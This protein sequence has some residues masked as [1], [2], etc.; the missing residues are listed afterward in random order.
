MRDPG[1]RAE[2]GIPRG[3]QCGV[4]GLVRGPVSHAGCNVGSVIAYM[5]PPVRA[6]PDRQCPTRLGKAASHETLMVPELCDEP[7]VRSRESYNIWNS[8]PCYF[9]K[10]PWDLHTPIHALGMLAM[11][12]ERDLEVPLDTGPE[13]RDQQSQSGTSTD[14]M[15]PAPSLSERKKTWEEMQEE[16]RLRLVTKPLGVAI[17]TWGDGRSFRRP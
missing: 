15:T 6:D 11:S 7:A 10:L 9:D 3:I 17:Q 4:Q 12:L 1:Q 16:K 14:G 2:S 8:Q 13:A 5:G